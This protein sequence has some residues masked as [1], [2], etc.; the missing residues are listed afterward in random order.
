MLGKLEL[1]QHDLAGREESA[2]FCSCVLHHN[3]TNYNSNCELWSTG[4]AVS[5]DGNH[6]H[7]TQ[8]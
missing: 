2:R 1:P 3:C 5:D 8:L 4:L 6:H 7:R